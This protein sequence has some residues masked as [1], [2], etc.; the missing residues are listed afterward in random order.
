MIMATQIGEPRNVL[1]QRIYVVYVGPGIG[2]GIGREEGRGPA[3]E[4]KGIN[5]VQSFSRQK[6]GCCDCPVNIFDSGARMR[7]TD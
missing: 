1:R 4:R 6:L 3:R 7:F 5:K 2:I